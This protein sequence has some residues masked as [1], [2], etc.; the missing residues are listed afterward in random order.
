MAQDVRSDLLRDRGSVSY[1]GYSSPDCRPTHSDLVMDTEPVPE[2]SLRVGVTKGEHL[3]SGPTLGSPIT[4][5]R[6]YPNFPLL[7]VD[8]VGSHVGE[9]I[10]PETGV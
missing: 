8:P 2:H 4:I 9:L 1:F 6:R 5:F 10:G 7:E 3:G